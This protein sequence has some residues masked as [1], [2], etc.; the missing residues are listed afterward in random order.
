MRRA[1]DLFGYTI[2]LI[3][4]A[5]FGYA[6]TYKVF[7][8]AQAGEISD[9]LAIPIWTGYSIASAGILAAVITSLIRWYQVVFLRR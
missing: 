4:M 8:I 7:D 1:F 9:D 2:N 6:I 3:F 5:G